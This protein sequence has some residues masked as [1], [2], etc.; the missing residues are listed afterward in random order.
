MSAPSLQTTVALDD[1]V[2]SIDEVADLTIALRIAV[3]MNTQASRAFSR[4]LMVELAKRHSQVVDELVAVNE[5]M[6]A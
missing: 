6:E 4:E 3:R 5:A 2:A 1:V